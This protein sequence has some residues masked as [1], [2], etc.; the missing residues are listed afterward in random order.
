MDLSLPTRTLVRAAVALAVVAGLLVSAQLASAK[1]HISRA[2]TERAVHSRVVKLYRAYTR[3]KTVQVK[4]KRNSASRYGCYY[5]VP[6]PTKKKTK[7]YLG[8]VDVRYR[9][10]RPRM[11]FSRPRCLGSGCPRKKG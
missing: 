6:M 5:L 1:A 3:A 11:T 4:C 7:I 8:N 9:H 10:A 2:S